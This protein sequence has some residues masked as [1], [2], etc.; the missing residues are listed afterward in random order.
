MSN[1]G[2]RA[3]F[4][5]ECVFSHCSL[6]TS[7]LLL[8]YDW[9]LHL[10]G[11]FF[12]FTSRYATKND[13]TDSM[14]YASA[15]FELMSPPLALPLCSR[16]I[17]PVDSSAITQPYDPALSLHPLSLTMIIVS[18]SFANTFLSFTFFSR[19]DPLMTLSS[20]SFS[21]SSFSEG[22]ED[23]LGIWFEMPRL[24][25]MAEVYAAFKGG[26]DFVDDSGVIW[27]GAML[28]SKCYNAGART[29]P[30]VSMRWPIKA[31]TVNWPTGMPVACCAYRFQHDW[32]CQWCSS[33]VC[34]S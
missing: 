4:A 2:F 3:S 8:Q 33:C 18:F 27:F 13:T 26:E 17:S 31:W 24:G 7:D 11:S 19:E 29:Y 16:K 34:T 5:L 28:G 9:I 12:G 6:L 15:L 14:S 20:K 21:H 1:L 22:L 30:Y 10:A 23:V 32:P 25:F